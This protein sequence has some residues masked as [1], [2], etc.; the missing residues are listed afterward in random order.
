MIPSITDVQVGKAI[1]GLL[2][3]ILPSAVTVIV[4]QV[5]RTASP[6]GDY[7]AMWPLRRPRFATN[8]ET[9]IDTKYTASIAPNAAG[10]GLMT[11]TAIFTGAI[12]PTNSVFGVNVA[13]STVVLQQ[14][15]GSPPGGVGTYQVSVSQIVA[16]ETMSSGTL[17]ILQST[18]AVWQI[19]AHG[20][21]SADNAQ[22]ISTVMRSSF[23]VDQMAGTGV[24]PLFAEDPR[25]AP[26][27]TAADQYEDRWM[28]DAHFE[29]D[30]IITTPQQ[31]SDSVALT[32]TDVQTYPVD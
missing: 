8:F 23:A 24:T 22:V 28:V 26:F 12:A 13:D 32:V 4:G 18:E 10:G 3:A 2:T 29:I 9:A 21:N 16:S 19:D 31:F 25:Q 14:I 1:G 30:P 5:N 17:E 15:S 7:V 20:P 27:V 11:V 6:Q